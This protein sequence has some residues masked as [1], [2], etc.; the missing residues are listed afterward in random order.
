MTKVLRAWVLRPSGLDSHLGQSLR[1]IIFFLTLPYSF[2]KNTFFA[3]QRGI[4][5]SVENFFLHVHSNLHF[6][7]NS[8]TN[9]AN[10]SN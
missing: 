1:S 8:L 7:W 6:F 5:F 2:E 10:T 4:L 9:F 3:I